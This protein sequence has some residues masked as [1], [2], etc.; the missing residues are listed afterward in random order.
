MIFID[1]C[2]ILISPVSK[3]FQIDHY[4]NRFFNKRNGSIYKIMLE[5][6]LLILLEIVAIALLSLRRNSDLFSPTKI[7]LLFSTF[8]YSAIF[9]ND[10]LI[11]TLI[12]YFFLIQMIAIC[13]FIEKKCNKSAIVLTNINFNRL[14]KII[15]IGS[16]P[17]IA[18]MIYFLF[19][20]GGLQQYLLSLALRVETWKGQGYFVVFMNTIAT[21]NLMYF[22]CIIKDNNNNLSKK[23]FYSLHFIL[24]LFVGLL[25]ASRSYVAVSLLGMCVMWTYLVRPPK[26]WYVLLLAG[27]LIIFASIVGAVRNN[28]Y[29][30]EFAEGLLDDDFGKS[31]F[32]NAQMAYGIMPLEIIFSSLEEVRLNGLSYLTIFTNFIPRSVWPEKPDTGGIIFTKLY[33]E[34]QTGLSYIATGAITEGILNFGKPVGAIVGIIINFFVLLFGCNFYN[35]I[36]CSSRARKFTS[37]FF[38]VA[39]FYIILACARFSY[40]EFTDIFQSLMLFNLMPLG[41]V[42]FALRFKLVYG[43]EL[44]NS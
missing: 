25:T 33:T 31:K 37:P 5:I 36:I 32:E 13:L 42:S 3:F 16:L 41:L 18:T 15:W 4:R 9:I 10:V 21:L 38:I 43:D 26:V 44:S 29:G 6:K 24:F 40:G 23:I 39:N 22:A 11:E 35:H 12:C 14:Y 8:F 27:F 30:G 19:E 7:Y 20:A 28:N 2:T 34:D 17:G 1:R